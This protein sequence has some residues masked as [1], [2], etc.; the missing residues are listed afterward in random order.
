MRPVRLMR[1]SLTLLAG[2]LLIPLLLFGM[3]GVP[4][5]ALCLPGVAAGDNSENPCAAQQAAADALRAENAA[6]RG[7]VSFLQTQTADM[8]AAAPQITLAP[9]ASDATVIIV[10]VLGRGDL[11]AEQV[12]LRNT[13]GVIDLTGWTLADT[14]GNVFVFPEMRLFSG[15]AI[16]VYSRSGSNTPVALFW[17]APAAVWGESGDAALLSNAAGSVQAVLQLP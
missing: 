6:L 8:G 14:Q 15:A 2:M 10:D 9:T 5:V 16:S 13:G 11:S 12:I 4:G 3:A 1:W 17:G 7:T